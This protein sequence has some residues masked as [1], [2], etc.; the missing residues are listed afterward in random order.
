M[1]R[2]GILFALDTQ[3][4]VHCRAGPLLLCLCP[5]PSSYVQYW[6]TPKSAKN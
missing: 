1:Q 3:S 2:P 4:T 6:R 5:Q